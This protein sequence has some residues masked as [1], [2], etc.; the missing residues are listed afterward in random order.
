MKHLLTIVLLLLTSCTP[1]TPKV[2]PQVVTVYASAAAQPW[3]ATL[4][5][6]AGSSAVLSVVPE[7]QSAEI[8]LRL[9]DPPRL[10]TTAYEIAREEIVVIVNPQNPANS[11]TQA[12]VFGLFMGQ[13][14]NWQEV[15]GEDAVVQVWVYSSGE[16]V[17][18][19]IGEVILEGANVSSMALLAADPD[20]MVRAISS[21]PRAI[22]V[23]S[24]NL[25]KGN[26]QLVNLPAETTS[27]LKVP[28]LAITPDEPP[29]VVKELLACLQE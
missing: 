21:D 24:K 2:V 1:A 27:V 9:G 15:G 20:E 14:R 29:G 26:V 5:D 23:L 16:D 3:L 25:V 19:I 12:Q 18:Q 28:V 4:Y 11:L 13:I 8:S 7:P 10:S 6:C 22:G 17:Q